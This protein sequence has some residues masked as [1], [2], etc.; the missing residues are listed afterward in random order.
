MLE[1]LTVPR[2][3]QS[4]DDFAHRCQTFARVPTRSKTLRQLYELRNHVEH[5]HEASLL[6]PGSSE[7]QRFDLADHRTRQA[8]LLARFALWRV[9]TCEAL[10]QHYKSDADIAAFWR[11][12]DGERRAIFGKPMDLD[13]I[14]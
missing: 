9:L 11:L 13:A 3:G 8:D 12:Q 7:R 5:M 2:V 1:G 6:L 4:T 10:F 14:R